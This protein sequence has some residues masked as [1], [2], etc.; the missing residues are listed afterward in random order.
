MEAYD[1]D[2][3]RLNSQVA[4]RIE[5]GALDKFVIEADSGSILVAP[6]AN[7][8]P[9]RTEPRTTF[10]NLMVIAV[11]GGVG[12]AQQLERTNV[13]IHINDVNNKPPIFQEPD[14][15]R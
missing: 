3:S 6:G 15:I 7:L 8:D 5:T 12:G 10:Y 2:G 14:I 1:A 11:D 13:V 4:Y 9:D